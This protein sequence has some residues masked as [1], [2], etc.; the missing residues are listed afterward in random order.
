MKRGLFVWEDRDGKREMGSVVFSCVWVRDNDVWCFRIVLTLVM[1]ERGWGFCDERA[2][3]V[4]WIRVWND[5]LKL[6]GVEKWDEIY[7]EE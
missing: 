5:R 7:K 2:R 3:F 6:F 4:G 1:E